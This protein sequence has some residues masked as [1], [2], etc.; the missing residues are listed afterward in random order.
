MLAAEEPD[1]METILAKLAVEDSNERCCGTNLPMATLTLLVNFPQRRGKGILDQLQLNRA[2]GQRI[3]P[4]FTRSS[5]RPSGWLE[6]VPV[7]SLVRFWEFLNDE[8]PGDPYAKDTGGG[9]VTASHEIYHFR[10]AVF[11]AITN[12][13]T[14]DACKAIEELKQR[15]PEDFWLGDVLATMRKTM[16]GSTWAPPTPKE[17]MELFARSEKRL[18]RSET[19]LQQLVADSLERYQARLRD[20]GQPL[21]L[22][23]EGKRSSPKSEENFSNC[24]KRFLVEDLKEHG[25][26]A[27]REVRIGRR[28]GDAP[29]Q[30]VDL[31]V[32][33]VNLDP[34]K[35]ASPRLQVVVE[36]KG[37]WN[38]DVFDDIK[39]QLRD[40]YLGGSSLNTGVY[41]VGYFECAAW[42]DPAAMRRK[43]GA[44]KKKIEE[45]R[46]C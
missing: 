41:V 43:T 4:E 27:N 29:A 11:Q 22:W 13:P 42:N 10:N 9:A 40:R 23:N 6:R 30:D 1:L 18:I 16:A 26:L 25:I 20:A 45:V 36:I 44:H 2:L 31:L 37:G 7:E 12:K 17:L 14:L 3:I 15:R 19:E 34:N 21:E 24:L 28:A 38:N 8:Y 5:H 46:K 33:L 32:Q 39:G 35:S